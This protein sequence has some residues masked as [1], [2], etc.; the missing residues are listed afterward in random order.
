MISETFAVPVHPPGARARRSA[1]AITSNIGGLI[2]AT[3]LLASVWELVG[4]RS[5]AAEIPA[6]ANRLF[7]Y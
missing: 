5:F 6:K 3:A 4:K 1:A 7:A 2:I